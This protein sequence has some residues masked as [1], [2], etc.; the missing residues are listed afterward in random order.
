MK[1]MVQLMVLWYSLSMATSTCVIFLSPV[2]PAVVV[3]VLRAGVARVEVAPLAVVEV[4]PE[5]VRRLVLGLRF[6]VA[7][8]I[9]SAYHTSV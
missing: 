2:F 4:V 6:T 9:V 8:K 1:M 5:I 7:C 3:V